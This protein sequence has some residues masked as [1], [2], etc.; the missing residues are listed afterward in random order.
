MK[1]IF[2][3]CFNH[4]L[5]IAVLLGS[6]GCASYWKRV[7]L[8]AV[9]RDWCQVVRAS[10]VLPVY[11][12]TE[13]IQPGDVFLVTRPIGQEAKLYRGGWFSAG[14]GFL[15]FEQHLARLQPL[16]FQ[17]F[18]G[19]SYGISE[20][21]DTPRHW[22]FPAVPNAESKPA[23]GSGSADALAPSRPVGSSD[24]E[25]IR[26]RASTAWTNAP[27]AAFPSYSFKVKSGSGLKLAVP[28]QGVPIGLNVMQAGSASG[29]ITISDAYTY[30]VSLDELSRSVESWSQNPDRLAMFKAIRDK[31]SRPIYVRVVS[32]VYLTGS[33]VV[34]L[35]SDQT[36]GGELS[37]G[38]SQEITLLEKGDEGAVKNYSA[39]LDLLNK[40]VEESL[41]GGTVKFAQASSRA[42]TM[43]ETFDRPLVIGYI[44][45]DFPILTD[46]SLG[47]P[48]STLERLKEKESPEVTIGQLSEEQ[49]DYG[50]LVAAVAS[51]KAE[52]QTKIYDQAA[53]RIG[54]NFAKDY[55]ASKGGGQSPALAFS[56]ARR[57]FVRASSDGQ[58]TVLVALRMAWKANLGND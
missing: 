16:D 47:V 8:E 18:Y 4:M 29:S 15:P 9:A 34:S 25:L 30:G 22:Q 41:P 24:K 2:S 13:D 28:V 1:P 11:P 42:V 14:K 31:A 10:Q 54:G 26:H 57:A 40:K 51:R 6:S 36:S 7:E 44:A 49:V 33:V 45:F 48:V 20:H 56:N 17:T 32:R 23:P 53:T 3:K 38:K 19:K 37:G 35:Q 55:A 5:L 12:L 46:G 21:K 39:I 58:S 50:L 27:R 43:H 52:T